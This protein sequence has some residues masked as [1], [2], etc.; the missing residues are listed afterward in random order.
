MNNTQQDS[1]KAAALIRERIGGEPI[2]FA[3][4]LGMGMGSFPSHLAEPVTIPF[5]DLPGFPT[6]GNDRR[7][8]LSVG[9]IGSSRI[10]VLDGRARFIEARDANA[11]RN[12]LE[13]VKLLG[14]KSVIV[15]GAVGS[16]RQELKPGAIVTIRDHINFSRINP[17]R[18]LQ[19]SDFGE[20]YVD[21]SNCYDFA[22][23]ER[24]FVAAGEIGRKV[25]EAVHFY[26]PGP[27]FETPAEV[28][29]ARLLG[30]DV[31]GM[32]IVPEVVIGSFLGLRMMA[33]AIVTNYAAELSE[34]R[35]TREQVHR[36]ADASMA[37]LSRI[38]VRFCEIWR[39]D[40][41]YV[42]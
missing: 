40:S 16:T 1:Q 3:I 13:T 9:R 2:D 41:A 28:A 22:L 23:R 6:L 10:A 39:L 12:V 21:L 25:P 14:A 20:G 5:S 29:A 35:I 4:M 37:S 36:V 32:S 38:L 30:G 34:D 33:L 31:V 19:M 7:G 24:F 11:M 8:T 42:A 26:M 27:N 18:L 17:L 15:T